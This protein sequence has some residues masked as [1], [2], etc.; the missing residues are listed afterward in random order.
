MA[1]YSLVEKLREAD[2]TLQGSPS[3]LG[4]T[5]LTYPNY[6][7]SMRSVMFT[8]H[9]GQFVNLINS[10][11]PH[12][13]TN[14]ENIVGEHNTAYKKA[15]SNF[16]VYK[17][18]SKF[19]DLLDKP[20][21]YKLF[22]YDKKNDFYDVIHRKD[23][24]DLTENFGYLINNDVIDS[25][26]EGDKIK[27][28]TVLWRSLSYDED[29]NYGYGINACVA[30]TLDPYTSEDAAKCSESF[31]KKMT[32]VESETIK[33]GLNSNDF[34][35]NQYGD[36]DH[37]KPL[38]DIGEKF[39]SNLAVIRRQFNNQLLYDFKDT[40][41]R[42][43]HEGDDIYYVGNDVVVTDYV[44]YDNNDEEIDSPFYEQINKYIRSQR[45]YYKEIKETCEEIIDSGAEYSRE[46][47]YLLKRSKEMLDRKKKWTEGYNAF[48]NM[49]IEVHTLRLDELHKGCKITG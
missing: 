13:F 3:L 45:K 32:S 33:I 27:K 16:T 40:A 7:N 9:L 10:E 49:M 21:V 39:S 4:K 42:E 19:D 11:Y 18:V 26:E 8:S 44:I 2:Q 6:I 17:K 35:I 15:D 28:G 24:E 34:M 46:I 23:C 37:Y 48:S 5:M 25:F 38:P 20:N 43:I 1:G 12:V 36:K 22:V 14:T 47:D 30:Y 41:L 29:M 31:A